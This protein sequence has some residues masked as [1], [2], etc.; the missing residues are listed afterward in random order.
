MKDCRIPMRGDEIQCF[1]RIVRARLDFSVVCPHPFGDAPGP[2]GRLHGEKKFLSRFT[3]NSR[4]P[5]L[6]GGAHVCQRPPG[7][8]N[9]T[10]RFSRAALSGG[11][12]Y[13]VFHKQ[14]EREHAR[15]LDQVW[16]GSPGASNRAPPGQGNAARAYAG[17][18]LEVSSTTSSSRGRQRRTLPS[19][20]TANSSSGRNS[21]CKNAITIPRHIP[22]A[23]V[24]GAK[25]HPP[26]VLTN[27][28]ESA[29]CAIQLGGGPAAPAVYRVPP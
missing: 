10:Q 16:H 2:H 21:L 12:F 27:S 20:V 25:L 23:T 14:L 22:S 15:A 24:T 5:L 13:G 7:L 4:Y 11:G 3:Q 9:F 19:V 28:I 17:G 8:E 18:R 6:F 26:S 29:P 1:A